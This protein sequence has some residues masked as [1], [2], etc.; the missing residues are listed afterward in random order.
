M[1]LFHIGLKKNLAIKVKMSSCY[2]IAWLFHFKMNRNTT[3][4]A[5]RLRSGPTFSLIQSSFEL[6]FGKA[7]SNAGGRA[8][9]FA[10]SLYQVSSVT[11]F[12]CA[13]IPVSFAY[14]ITDT[15]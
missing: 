14:Y 9:F 5:Q 7:S 13:D 12:W 4:K 3:M 8:T 6:S 11:E 10:T 15:W 2:C 1:R